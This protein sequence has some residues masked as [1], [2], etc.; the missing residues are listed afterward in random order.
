MLQIDYIIIDVSSADAAVYLYLHEV[1]EGQTD[2][3]GLLCKLPGRR[4]DQ[5]LWLS[6]GHVKT[7]ES[8]KREYAGLTCAT[9]AL[10]NDVSPLDDR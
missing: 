9:L 6:E 5:H 7:V 8:T 4:K 10:R 3:L 2:S 1:A